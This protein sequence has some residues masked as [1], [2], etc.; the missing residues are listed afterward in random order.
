MIFE[1]ALTALRQGAKIW[2]PTFSDDEYL[3]ACRLGLIGD[4]TPI[5]DK[6]ISIV[7]IKSGVEHENMGGKLLYI[8]KIKR[9]LKEILTEEDYKKYH[10]VWTDI[11]IGE[12]FDDDIFQ[13]PQ[14]NLFLVMSDEWKLFKEPT[15]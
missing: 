13:C 4:D 9:Q 1:E 8:A 15:C 3:M 2:H 14:L 11:D 6:P 12:I 10:T 5:K 7:R